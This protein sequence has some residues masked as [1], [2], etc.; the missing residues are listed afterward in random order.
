MNWLIVL[1]LLAVAYVFL[2][3][4]LYFLAVLAVIGILLFLLAT[5]QKS[6]AAAS[7]GSAGAPTIIESSGE[8]IPERMFIKVKPE[9][10]DRKSYEY[11]S[12]HI[13][14][15]LDNLGRGIVFLLTGKA[16]KK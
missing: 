16:G 6:H 3:A 8:E 15:G 14:Y 10:K 13:G 12:E 9:W 5:P 7:A 11:L 2:E 4:G 1:V